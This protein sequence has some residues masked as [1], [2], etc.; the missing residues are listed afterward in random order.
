MVLQDRPLQPSSE[1]PCDNHCIFDWDDNQVNRRNALCLSQRH[2]PGMSTPTV[3]MLW[4]QFNEWGTCLYLTQC[5]CLSEHGHKEGVRVVLPPSTSVSFFTAR[6]LKVWSAVHWWPS[7][8]FFEVPECDMKYMHYIS[9][10]V[11]LILSLSTNLIN[12]LATA[13]TCANVCQVRNDSL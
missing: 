1:A 12:Y 7:K 4:F 13:S 5:C 2:V 6:L 8:S 9:S 3:P 10:S 11:H